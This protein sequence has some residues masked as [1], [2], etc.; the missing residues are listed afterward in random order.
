MK[1]RLPVFSS[2]LRLPYIAH[3]KS[4]TENMF[5]RLQKKWKVNN[6]QLVL[7]LC[8]FAIG[9]S[10]TGFIGK[11][12]MNALAI[13]QDWLWTLVY[14]LLIT[15]IWPLAVII[16]S[17]PFGQFSFFSRYIR[18]IGNKI[19]I[20]GN[21][22]ESGVGSRESSVNDN[23]PNLKVIRL[24]IF[25]SGAGSNAAKIIDHFRNHPT[26]KIVLVAG[27]NPQAG[28]FKI[29]EKNQ[30][31]T[32]FLEKNAFF[33]SNSYKNE[34]KSA[35][36]DFIVLAGFL[37]QIPAVLIKEYAGKIVNIHPALLPK[38]GGKGMYGRF[39][40]EAV[41]ASKEK[42]SGITIHYVDEIYDHGHVIFQAH[43]PVM[44][45][46]TGETLAQRILTLEHEHYPV[47]IEK[48]LVK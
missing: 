16:I 31:S 14:I 20:G 11:K 30:I 1:S 46:D 45:T 15:L 19:G 25:A 8:T 22:Q 9:G 38:Y 35:K 33:S 32:R 48:L 37:W 29:A 27:N 21:S 43:C 13:N 47:V 28:V 40:H 41:I 5:E 44:E 10:V 2:L 34:L 6:L 7:I 17:I 26:V 18:K 3:I 12:V 36:I 23:I 39:V 24:A 4:E 42:E